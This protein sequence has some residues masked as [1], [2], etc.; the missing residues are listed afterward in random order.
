MMILDM[1][2]RIAPLS[3]A[4]DV[5]ELLLADAV[6]DPEDDE[7]DVVSGP[8]ELAG[9]SGSTVVVD[10]DDEDEPVELALALV[11]LEGAK[12]PPFA[13][14]TTPKPTRFLS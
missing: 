7:P 4:G 1:P 2:G 3:D 14:S 6:L 10:D 5:D 11:V 13:S 8:D 9:V 12:L